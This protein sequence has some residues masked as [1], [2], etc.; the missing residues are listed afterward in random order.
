MEEETPGKD[1]AQEDSKEKMDIENDKKAEEK[2]SDKKM[3]E[4]KPKQKMEKKMKKV[5][6]YTQ[7]KV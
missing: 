5:T 7:L 2:E 1:P 6:N 3:E 4:E